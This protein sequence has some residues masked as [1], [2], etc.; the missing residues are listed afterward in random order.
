MA[1]TNTERVPEK[2]TRPA[3]ITITEGIAFFLAGGFLIGINPP[4]NIDDILVRRLTPVTHITGYILLAFGLMYIL[5]LIKHLNFIQNGLAKIWVYAYGFVF[6]VSSLQVLQIALTPNQDEILRWASVGLLLLVFLLI[7]FSP[8][9]KARVDK[10]RLLST[11]ILTY[12]G[13]AIIF[14]VL[15]IEALPKDLIKS[16][17]LDPIFLL[18]IGLVCAILLIKRIGKKDEPKK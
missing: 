5:P 15:R 1:E 12:N 14:F 9:A 11:L 13:L 16:Q 4:P 8:T 2:E 18:L 6:A 17:N 3:L 7:M 10:V